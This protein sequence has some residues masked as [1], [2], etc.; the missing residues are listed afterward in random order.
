MA[1][2]YFAVFAW[3]LNIVVPYL[4]TRYDRRR[5]KPEQLERAWNVPSWACAVF[6]FGPFCLPAHFWI[7]RRTLIGFLQ[8]A[9]W[10]VAMLGSEYLLAVGIERALGES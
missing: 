6:F 10:A 5:L 8:G 3:V 7:T 4:I 1:E 2:L 9:A